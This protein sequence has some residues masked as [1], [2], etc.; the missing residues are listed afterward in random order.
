[1][2]PRFSPLEERQVALTDQD[3]EVGFAE[4]MGEKDALT[5]YW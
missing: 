2:T 3:Y 1:M 4:I 5:Q